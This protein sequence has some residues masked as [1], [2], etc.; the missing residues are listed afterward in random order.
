[1]NEKTIKRQY[2]NIKRKGQNVFKIKIKTN[3]KNAQVQHA[4]IIVKILF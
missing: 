3:K 1:M 4:D 2:R